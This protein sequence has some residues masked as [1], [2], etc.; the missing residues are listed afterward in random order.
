MDYQ[1]NS[2]SGKEQVDIQI[3]LTAS[4]SG[5]DQKGEMRKQL[6]RIKI[7]EKDLVALTYT[8]TYQTFIKERLIQITPP[9]K[10]NNVILKNVNF[11]YAA[12]LWDF[13]INEM[14]K[15]NVQENESYT[16]EYMDKGKAKKFIDDTFLLDYLVIKC[17]ENP[18]IKERHKKEIMEKLIANMVEKVIDMNEKLSEDQ[19][20]DIVAKQYKITKYKNQA[21]AKEIQEIFKKY[22]TKYVQKINA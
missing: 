13:L 8:T 11:Q 1:G 14:E 18:E 17:V 2:Y 19:L 7:L 15:N 22:I 10:K 3:L 12:K 4:G 5:E 9:L 6:E 16:K 21:T 20:K